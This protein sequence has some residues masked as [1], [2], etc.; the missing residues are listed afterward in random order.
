MQEKN[1]QC[2]H[3]DGNSN[4][5]KEMPELKNTIAKM[6]NNFDGLISRLVTAEERISEL[7]DIS[8]ESLK[9][10]KQRQQDKKKKK[11]NN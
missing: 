3:R 7:E 4:N 10:K 6:K 2:K 5:Q 1:R 11:K 9:S 8:I